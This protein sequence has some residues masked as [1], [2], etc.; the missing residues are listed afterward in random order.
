MHTL[1]QYITALS[2]AVFITAGNF[3]FGQETSNAKFGKISPDDFSASKYTLAD[4]GTG[5]VILADIGSTKFIGNN[6]GWFSHEF[7]RFTRIKILN[8]TAF[9]AATS[10]IFLY[11]REDDKEMLSDVKAS[12]YNLENGKIIQAD[13]QKKDIYEDRYSANFIAKKFTLPGIKEG[14]IIEL[15]YTITSDFDFR[16][17]SWEFQSTEY[18]CLWSEYQVSIPNL[19]IY[20]SIRQGTDS[21]SITKSWVSNENYLITK[22][23]GKTFISGVQ[24]MNVSSLTN[25]YRWVMKDVQPIKTEAYISSPLNYVDKIKFQLYQVSDGEDAKNVLNTWPITSQELLNDKNFGAGLS[26]NPYWLKDKIKELESNSSGQLQFAQNAY[27][28]VKDNFTCT[29]YNTFWIKNSLKNVFTDLH[30]NVGELN[31]LLTL[32]LRQ[33]GIVANP[34]LL[35]TQDNGVITTGYPIIDDFNYLV[36]RAEIDGVTYYLDCS[37]PRLGFGFL[38]NTCYN[39]Q[40]RIVNT[41]YA[42]SVYLSPD[43]VKENKTVLVTI[44]NNDQG[45]SAGSLTQTPGMFESYNIRNIISA[46]KPGDY[47]KTLGDYCPAD[48][49]V[50]NITIDSLKQLEA[51]LAIK[52]DFVVNPAGADI[53]YFNPFVTGAEKKNPFIAASRNFPV[54]MP[55]SRQD[56]YILNMEVPK[57]YKVEELPKSVRMKLGES[58]G[59]FEYIA[60]NSNNH[61]QLRS[62]L[63]LNKANFEAGYYEDLRNF[64]SFVVKKQSEQIV[65]KKN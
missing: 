2:I 53:F 16:L 52:Y 6:K 26:E 9:K 14:S 23:T 1:T 55:W 38:P 24:D 34:V 30:G 40:A 8:Q 4:P 41:A 43:A 20:A 11:A 58:D 12:T 49:P 65:F 54:M 7:R 35:S 56:I 37:H 39:G 3:A 5:A 17:H 64:F 62:T 33:K 31:L 36:C 61:I 46:S 27:Y 25:N 45:I 29:G 22:P 13:L 44:S 28:Y 51:P 59:V 60:V 63:V 47:A 57:G 42:D 15:S 10:T 32:I 50:T 18:P 48:M 21:F 19:L